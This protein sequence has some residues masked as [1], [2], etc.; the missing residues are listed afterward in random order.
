MAAANY[1]HNYDGELIMDG[2]R[3]AYSA[4][5]MPMPSEGGELAPFDLNSTEL[6]EQ[7]VN[8]LAEHPAGGTRDE[9]LKELDLENHRIQVS[10]LLREMQERG[11]VIVAREK[12]A[13]HVAWLVHTDIGGMAMK[14]PLRRGEKIEKID[15]LEVF[16]LSPQAWIEAVS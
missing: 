5:I 1:S 13:A 6:Y 16:R 9:L 15:Y 12:R 11:D 10:F 14:P 2:K 7:L 8:Y 4:S 3:V